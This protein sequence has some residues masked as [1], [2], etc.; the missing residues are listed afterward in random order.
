MSWLIDGLAAVQSLQSKDIYREWIENLIC[1]I[2]PLEV[3][4]CL[5]VGM[6]NDT[7][8]EQVPKMT[9][10]IREERTIYRQSHKDLNNI[11]QL[12]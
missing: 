9:P 12:V 4:E 10:K 3:A 7:Y 5:L 2:T 8:Q 6:V 11:C 1:F